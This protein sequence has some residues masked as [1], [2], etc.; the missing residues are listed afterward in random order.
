M[1]KSTRARARE[2]AVV[3]E[4]IIAISMLLVLLACAWFAHA[5][6]AHKLAKI[7]E[8][9]NLAWGATDPE[10]THGGQGNPERTAVIAPYPFGHY[11][12]E[13]GARTQLRC[14]EVP[15]EHS[16]LL[17]ALEWGLGATVN[18]W[19]ELFDVVDAVRNEE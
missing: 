6:Y 14:N 17:A 11:A 15:M 7:Y 4:A 1:K 10:C 2:G 16:D 18:I 12:I 5:V 9:R 3:I 8:A 13:V 19:D